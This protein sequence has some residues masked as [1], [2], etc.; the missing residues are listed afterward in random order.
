MQCVLRQVLL[1]DT[2]DK[3]GICFDSSGMFVAD[4]M[5]LAGDGEVLHLMANYVKDPN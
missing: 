2:S 1:W 4:Q 3:D 5:R